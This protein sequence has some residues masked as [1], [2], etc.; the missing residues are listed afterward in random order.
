MYERREYPEKSWSFSR[1][2]SFLECKR[3]FYFNTYGHWNGWEYK[4]PARAKQV[5]RLK[6]L[7]NIYTLSGQLLHEEIATAIKSKSIDVNEAT[8]RIRHLLNKAVIDSKEKLKYW[9]Q[10]PKDYVIL[11]EY[12]YG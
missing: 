9:K 12:Y 4:A 8:N 1:H 11:H 2:K 5:Y 3:S 7:S 10:N 6:K